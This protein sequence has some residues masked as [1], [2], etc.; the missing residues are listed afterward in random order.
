MNRDEILKALAHPTRI[1]MLNWLKEPEKHFT[2]EHPFEM[3]VCASGIERNCGLSQSA[4]SAHL[5][6]L[7]RAELVTS[8]RVG[9]WIFYKRNEETIAAFLKSLSDL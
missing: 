7:S 9:Q 8:R 4:V 1:D 6:T 3:G 2:Q 5:A